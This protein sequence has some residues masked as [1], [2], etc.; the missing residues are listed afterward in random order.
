[1]NTWIDFCNYIQ[2]S[3]KSYQNGALK[4]IG[5]KEIDNVFLKKLLDNT[6]IKT[7][8]ID[9][10]LPQEAYQYIDMILAI[11]PDMTFRIFG[12]MDAEHFDIS[13]LKNMPHLSNLCIDCYSFN[14]NYNLIDFSVLTKLNLK[15][16]SL[17]CF[18]L[19][20]YS[21][22]QNLSEE[23]NELLIFA[24][25]TGASIKFDCRWLLRFKNLK[26]LW[27]GK[28]ANKNLNCLSQLTSLK[29]LSLRGIKLTDFSFLKNL[30]LEKLTLLWN[31]NNDL[32]ELA[33]LK[34]LKEIKLFRINKLSDISFIKNLKNLEVI[35][36]QCLKH[37]TQLPD[38]SEHIHLKKLILFKTGIDEESLPD[39]LRKK[40]S[41]W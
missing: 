8:Q 23:L 22:I 25:T 17:N 34:D 11:R 37:V 18:D 7:V 35:N 9:E 4:A 24:D 20:D 30:K 3:E 40:I 1:M 33:E 16:L 28:K 21:F 2:I 13:F 32:H 38:L 10:I 29:S 27:L 19:R 5:Y 31:S 15:S 36:L 26:T 14:N 6:K 39:N 12:L 41:N